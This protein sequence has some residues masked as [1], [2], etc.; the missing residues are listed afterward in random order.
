MAM[1]GSPLSLVTVTIRKHQFTFAIFLTIFPLSVVIMS[2]SV[3]YSGK[4]TQLTILKLSFLYFTFLYTSS[5][6]PFMF[7][8]LVD[9]SEVIHFLTICSFGV[10]LFL[11]DGEVIFESVVWNAVKHVLARQCFPFF[12]GIL[13]DVLRLRLKNVGDLGLLLGLVVDCPEGDFQ[14]EELLQKQ[15]PYVWLLLPFAPQKVQHQPECFRISIDEN[16]FTYFV[17]AAIWKFAE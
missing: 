9:L 8:F 6:E 14:F 16:S 2:L 15:V 13:V 5:A 11:N 3:N 7:S 12:E 17:R 10:G 1:I 4:S